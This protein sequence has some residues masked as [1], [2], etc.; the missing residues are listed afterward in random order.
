MVK[1]GGFRVELGEIEHVFRNQS[2]VQEVVVQALGERDNR[3]LAAWV[4]PIADSPAPSK[5]DLTTAVE[6]KLPAYMVPRVLVFI[7]SFPVTSN[8]KLDRK[9]LEVP[10]SLEEMEPTKPASEHETA[11]LALFR[12][13]THPGVTRTENFFEVSGQELEPCRLPSWLL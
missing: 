9:A 11:I 8:G 5:H 1:I 2:G 7:K 12:E 3:Y 13:F 4:Q 10:H 6:A